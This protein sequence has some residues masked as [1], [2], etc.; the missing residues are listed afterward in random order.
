M[1]KK[2]IF[3]RRLAIYLYEH[4]CTIL[5]TEPNRQNPEWD[6]WIFEDGTKLQNCMAEYIEAHRK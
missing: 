4:G 3:T 5:D 6:V 2:K 1:F